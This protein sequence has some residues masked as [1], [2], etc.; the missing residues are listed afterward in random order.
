LSDSTTAASVLARPQDRCVVCG[1]GNPRGLHIHFETGADG[2]VTAEC[3]VSQYWEGFEGILHGG[4]IATLLDEGM[5]KAIVA[6]NWHAL[7][8]ELRVRYREFVATGERL[9]LRAWVTGDK[10]RKILA[11][12]TLTTAAGV[13]KAHAWGTF[14]TVS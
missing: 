1:P 7:T 6:S 10:K 4:I 9:R 12:A 14:L 2:V 3:Q 13:E 5:S 8:C 11:E